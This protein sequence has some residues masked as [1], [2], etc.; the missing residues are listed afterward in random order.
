L[1]GFG[2]MVDTYLSLHRGSCVALGEMAQPRTR[3]RPLPEVFSPRL[4]QP[5]FEAQ[6]CAF[7]ATIPRGAKLFVGLTPSP[8]ASM[9]R[10]VAR[11]QHVDLLQR[12]NAWLQADGV[13]TNLPATLPPGDFAFPEHLNQAG[14]KY[15]S[16]KAAREL[17]Q[18]SDF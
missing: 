4:L 8:E 13:L 5:K 12:W 15:F 14:Q 7:R 3:G 6:S 18:C 11:Q 2:S 1:L 9:A 17:T 16:T 10:P